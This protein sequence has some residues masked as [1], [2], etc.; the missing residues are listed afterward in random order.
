MTVSIHIHY[1]SN[2]SITRITV[3]NAILKYGLTDI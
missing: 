2:W 3:Q 1:G